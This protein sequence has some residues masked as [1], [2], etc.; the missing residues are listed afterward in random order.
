M[1]P[2]VYC[3]SFFFL[4]FVKV[5]QHHEEFIFQFLYA[6]ETKGRVLFNKKQLLTCVWDLSTQTSLTTYWRLE[7]PTSCTQMKDAMAKWWTLLNWQCLSQWRSL[8][9]NRVPK[10][11]T[12][13]MMTWRWTSIPTS[14][15]NTAN[16]AICY[17]NHTQTAV[18]GGHNQD[19]MLKSRL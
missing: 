18:W 17:G 5:F 1:T 3:D 12:L 6:S 16:I 13:E 7:L 15:L 4:F 14:N 11:E 2:Y 8:V 9:Y 19:T 10:N